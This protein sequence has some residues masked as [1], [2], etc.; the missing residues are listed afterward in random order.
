MPYSEEHKAARE[1]A[2][3]KVEKEFRLGE[4]ER[5]AM[6][7]RAL[8][9]VD[10]LYPDSSADE[11]ISGEEETGRI[12]EE[13]VEYSGWVLFGRFRIV[14]PFLNLACSLLFA[15]PFLLLGFLFFF[16]MTL[17]PVYGWWEAESWPGVDC[18]IIHR[19]VHME[20]SYTWEGAEFTSTDY[21]FASFWNNTGTSEWQMYKEGRVARCFVNPEEP[22]EAVLSKS[23][24][25]QYL[26]GLA[27][28]LPFGFGLVWALG[29]GFAFM[30]SRN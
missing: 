4:D 5:A 29:S 25:L 9:M 2:R 13:P 15:S 11:S 18:T 14:N 23:F 26:V 28:L 30:R 20:Y 16:I 24:S 21:D 22:W 8:R 7:E 1:E 3:K 10:L 19:G 12:A 6:L 17:L 27:G